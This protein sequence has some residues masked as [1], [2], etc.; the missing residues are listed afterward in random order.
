MS[1]RFDE[2]HF[3]RNRQIPKLQPNFSLVTS[4]SAILIAALKQ[5]TEHLVNTVKT[6]RSPGSTVSLSP[7]V[8]VLL[9]LELNKFGSSGNSGQKQQDQKPKV[10]QGTKSAPLPRNINK[11]WE[12]LQTV[13]L[14]RPICPPMPM[15][16]KSNLKPK[17]YFFGQSE[18]RNEYPVESRNELV[19]K[20][21]DPPQ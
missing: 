17:N 19:L 4:I 12:I 9:C 5:I 20:L 3:L 14:S 10:H 1:R 16:G 2:F 7:L 11:V 8:I 15:P 13:H 18:I 21:P 6:F